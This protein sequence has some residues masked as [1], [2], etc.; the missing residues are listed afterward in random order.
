M[1]Q[2]ARV[3]SQGNWHSGLRRVCADLC[4]PPKSGTDPPPSVAGGSAGLRIRVSGRRAKPQTGADLRERLL[5][6]S[7]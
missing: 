1:T 5:G 2:T 4:A 7:S 3:S 6:W